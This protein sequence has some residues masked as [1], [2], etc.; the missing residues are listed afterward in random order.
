MAR[1]GRGA[2]VPLLHRADQS[3]DADCIMMPLDSADGAPNVPDS[4]PGA[5]DRHVRVVAA[6]VAAAEWARARRASWS[7]VE[8]PRRIIQPGPPASRRRFH[9]H[10]SNG[11]RPLR[12]RPPR[13]RRSPL[14]PSCRR[15]FRSSV[16]PGRRCQMSPPRRPPRRSTS[17][18]LCRCRRWP[19]PRTR[20]RRPPSRASN[21]RGPRSRHDWRPPPRRSA[22]PSFAGR[23]VSWRWRCSRRA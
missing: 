20:R 6:A 12:R 18:R 2:A 3:T 7:D 17:R 9:R 19:R 16:R 15:G 8:P 22:A 10:P 23:P 5:A 21:A 1:A 13:R 14:R 11:R 4:D